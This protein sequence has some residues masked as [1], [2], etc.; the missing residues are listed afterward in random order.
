VKHLEVF[1]VSDS[2]FADR[3]VRC[4]GVD[5]LPIFDLEQPRAV[6]AGQV[7]HWTMRDHDALRTR[8]RFAWGGSKAVNQDL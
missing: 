5:V 6:A 1:V 7:H 4:E 8:P 2:I 3:V